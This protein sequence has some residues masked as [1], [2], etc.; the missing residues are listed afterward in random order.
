MP[1]EIFYRS[2]S[3]LGS[4]KVV[5]GISIAL[6][7]SF[8]IA[9]AGCGTAATRRHQDLEERITDKQAMRARKYAPD[10]YA[11]AEIALRLAQEHAKQEHNEA[12]SDYMAMARLYLAAAEIEAD[13]IEMETKTSVLLKKSADI[14]EQIDHYENAL[15]ELHDKKAKALAADKARHE[16]ERV[17]QLALEDEKHKL[18]VKQQKE[19]ALT[20][21]DR[22][23]LNLSAAIALSAKTN[24]ITS[25]SEALEKAKKTGDLDDAQR[26]F[27]DTLSVLSAAQKTKTSSSDAERQAFHDD[28]MTLGFRTINGVYGSVIEATNFFR[29]GNSDLPNTSKQI[30]KKLSKLL[31]TY[32]HGP[33][34]VEIA[35][36]PFRKQTSEQQYEERK[37]AI[38]QAFQDLKVSTDSF[39]ISQSSKKQST[40]VRIVFLAYN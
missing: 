15:R 23:T 11:K 22:A 19:A 16:I 24:A 6:M 3:I 12:H 8:S 39:F 32:N 26:A 40:S 1:K 30:I 35:S 28:A 10:L 33:I 31:N 20:L 34:L 29:S 4:N 36:S 25:A 18:S 2:A 5:A 7:L 27:Q 13:R 17:H 37:K 21:I 9:Y 38:L 14:Q